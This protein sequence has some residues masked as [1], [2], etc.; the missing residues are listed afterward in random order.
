MVPT[1][2]AVGCLQEHGNNRM[3]GW[4]EGIEGLCSLLFA[5]PFGTWADRWRRDRVLRI[6]SCIELGAQCH[7]SKRVLPCK[8]AGETMDVVLCRSSACRQPAIS[9]PQAAHTCRLD[10]NQVRHP[11]RLPLP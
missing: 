7:L 5:I 1:P 4:L 3:V 9:R 2:N 6:S 8:V 11:C 10:V